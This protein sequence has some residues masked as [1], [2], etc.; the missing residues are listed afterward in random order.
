MN[1]YPQVGKNSLTKS[2]KEGKT[3]K[4]KI[5]LILTFSILCIGG[6]LGCVTA[7]A[8]MGSGAA[9]VAAEVDMVKTGLSGKKLCFSDT[10]FKSALTLTDFDT[11]TVTRIPASTEGTLLIGGRRVSEGRV[12]KRKNL[13][14]LVFVPATKDVKE[15]SFAFTVDGYAGGAEIECRMRF[16]DSINYAPKTEE[17]SSVTTQA[18]ISYYGNL[19]ATEPEDDGLKFMIVSYPKRGMLTIVDEESGRYCYTPNSGYTGNDK[20]VFVARDEYGNYSELSTVTVKVCDRMC[21]TVYSDMEERAEYNAAVAMTAMN[22]MSGELLG[23]GMY[24]MPDEQVSR[25]EFVAMAMKCAGIRADSTLTSTY[26]DDDSDIPTG[27]RSYI[28]TAQRIGLI[29]GDFTD[30]KLLFSPN[31]A[32]TGYEAARI[33]AELLGTDADGEESVFAA[34][35][36]IPVWAR[37]GVG[38]MYSLG[39][40]DANEGEELANPVTRANAAAYL[41]KMSMIN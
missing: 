13:A 8:Y 17:Q 38:A 40:F 4:R 19:S 22:I 10:D 35:E 31:E 37:A 25:A 30:G 23:D 41:Y 9:A 32:I 36:Q 18:D 28:A 14:S 27:L 39:I 15:C 26:F 7:S 24:F 6:I 20:F 34:D 16:L 12:I 3:M 2:G 5:A 29:N 21:D 11:I 1:K 33:M